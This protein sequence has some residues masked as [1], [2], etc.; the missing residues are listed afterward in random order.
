MQTTIEGKAEEADLLLIKSALADKLNDIV[1]L[2]RELSILALSYQNITE[3][4]TVM[5]KEDLSPVTKADL[6]IS[7]RIH[8]WLLKNF[9]HLQPSPRFICEERLKQSN[10]P[11]SDLVFLVDPIDGTREFVK[12]TKFFTINI[13]ICYKGEP[14]AGFVAAPAFSEFYYG[15]CGK[16]AFVMEDFLKGNSAKD[17]FKQIFVKNYLNLSDDCVIKIL[18]SSNSQDIAFAKDFVSKNN[19]KKFQLSTVNSSF[20]GCLV[21]KGSYD[22]YLR[23]SPTNQWDIAAVHAIVI[24]AGGCFKSFDTEPFT[25]YAGYGYNK[26]IK[27]HINNIFKSPISFYLGACYDKSGLSTS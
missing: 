9:S 8:D 22:F 21:A 20:K 1:S 14:V 4:N 3:P 24:A 17:V 7:A 15:I 26:D 5:Q 23:N 2:M 18:T 12:K 27:T 19:I 25:G 11:I 6:E 10:N 13:A 16:G